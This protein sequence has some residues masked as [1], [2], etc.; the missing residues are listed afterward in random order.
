MA[1]W[2]STRRLS[3]FAALSDGAIVRSVDSGVSVSSSIALSTLR[4]S[5][6]SAS[7][8]VDRFQ[9]GRQMRLDRCEQPDRPAMVRSRVAA[10]S[11]RSSAAFSRSTLSTHVRRHCRAP[12]I[13]RQTS[14]S[15]RRRAY[16]SRLV[17]QGFERLEPSRELVRWSDAWRILV[18]DRGFCCWFGLFEPPFV[19]TAAT[20]GV[21]HLMVPICR[22]AGIERDI[23]TSVPR[24]KVNEVIWSAGNPAETSGEEDGRA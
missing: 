10:N 12:R 17:P 13:R 16:A 11:S 6:L 24:E 8:T 15:L 20:S 22:H 14:E 21:A 7:V 5:C 3:G 18:S 23:A 19:S 9:C 1:S 2:I 4:S